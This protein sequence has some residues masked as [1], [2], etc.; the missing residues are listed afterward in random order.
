MI[1]MTAI[2][3]CDRCGTQSVE[4]DNVANEGEVFQRLDVDG[5]TTDTGEDL[6]PDCSDEDAEETEDADAVD[7]ADGDTTK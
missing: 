5:W 1:D 4:M 7:P 3:T 2:V 6:C